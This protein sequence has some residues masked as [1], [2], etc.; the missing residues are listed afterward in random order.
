MFFMYY[1]KLFIY[2]LKTQI[3]GQSQQGT[4]GAP[5][6]Y[7]YNEYSF[8]DIHCEMEKHRLPRPTSKATKEKK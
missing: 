4:Y 6:Y 1:L 7:Q 3:L 8:N 2:K 5:E